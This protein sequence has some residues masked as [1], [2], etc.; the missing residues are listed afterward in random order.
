MNQ[1]KIKKYAE[2]IVRKGANVQKGQDV[3]IGLDVSQYKFGELL[4]EECYK[5]GAAK[6]TVDWDND[7]LIRLDY[8]YRSEEN[9][10]DVLP[11][12]EEKLKHYVNTLP[13]RIYIESSDPDGLKGVDQG[14][15]ARVRMARYPKIKK[16]RDAMENKY[17]WVIAGMPS[18]AWA[19]KVFPDLPEDEAVEKLFDAIMYTSR[20]TDDPIAEWDKHNADLAK[21]CD[22]L[23]S[24]N[25]KE[26]RYKSPNGT[27]LKVGLIKNCL[28]EGGGETAL[29]SGIYFNPNMPTE[30][31]FTSPM[32]GEAEGI[33]YSTKPL[34]Y[35]GEIIDKFYFRFE[36]GKVVEA[37]A[38]V[39]DELLH[40][41]ISLDE[42][43]AYL[44]EC[45]LVPVDSPVS[46]SNILFFNTL[47]DE[48]ASCHLAL[49]MGFSNLIKDYEKYTLEE[50]QAMG[51]N[52]SMSHVDFMIGCDT[53]DII[54]VSEDGTEHQIFKNG[55]WAF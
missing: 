29:G 32:K 1:E 16:Y 36:K 23:N 46:N 8:N 11:W 52:D 41:M 30:E 33:V 49:G 38:E 55:N 18:P 35:N 40:H 10:S 54:G 13:C 15:M 26:L 34:S 47:Y 42:G 48:N 43:A 31:C 37:H 50:L 25:L 27:D 21:R 44:G 2:L 12:Q 9:L 19:K 28:F 53:L 5:A 14:K 51:I 39:G 3:V 45:A 6:V 20:V 4:V 22:Y 7:N 17:Q 24:L